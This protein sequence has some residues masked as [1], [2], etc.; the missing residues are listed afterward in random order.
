VTG[1]RLPR[2]KAAHRAFAAAVAL[3][4]LIG[5]P[6]WCGEAVLKG[7][8]VITKTERFT[9]LSP[10]LV[11]LEHNT[12]GK[13]VDEPSLV[14][15]DRDWGKMALA[16]AEKRTSLEITTDKLRLRYIPRSGRF[17]SLNLS[18]ELR[19]GG[20]LMT[21]RPGVV[22]R[23]NLG[24]AFAGIDGADGPVELPDG[25]LSR[26][27]WYLLND[28]RSPVLVDGWPRPRGPS[29]G[30]DLYF[31]GYGDDYEQG[32]K[33][34][35]NL[36]GKMP[37]PPRWTL[38]VWLLCDWPL[39]QGRLLSIVREFRRHGIRLDAL[40]LTHW[41]RN[42]WGSYEWN[43]DI[44]PDP[45]RFLEDAHKLGVKV[46]LNIH[47][48]GALLPIEPGYQAVTEIVGWDP[49]RRGMVFFDVSNEKQA[50]AL[51]DALLAPL[52]KQG[53]DF[54]WV[55]GSA[56][57]TVRR[58]GGQWWTNHL[59]FN[60]TRLR[61]D[62]RGL[63]LGRCAGLGSQ[64]FPAAFSGIPK[65]NW[66]ILRFLSYLTPTA[67]NAG[68][69]YMGNVIEESSNGKPDNE[70]FVRWLQFGMACPLMILRTYRG[71]IPWMQDPQTLAHAGTT[72]RLRR[73]FI[74]YLYTLASRA[75]RDG[76]PLCRPMYIH[77]PTMAAAYEFPHQYMLGRGMIIAPIA[78][79][80][81][82]DSLES[83]KRIW[84]PPGEWHDFIN[85][86]IIEGPTILNYA[87]QLDHMPVFAR[88]GSI[89][90]LL[91]RPGS[92]ATR[93][94]RL[95]L[96]ISAGE[97]GLFEIYNDDGESTAYL[98]EHSG[99][100]KC[101][102]SYFESDQA[103]TVIIGDMVGD[104][105]GKPAKRSYE[106][107]L[108]SFLPAKGVV[109]NGAGMPELPQEEVDGDGDRTASA[110]GPRPGWYYNVAS[111]RLVVNT[112][113]LP[114]SEPVEVV[115]VGEFG[116]RK[117][118]LAYLL[119]EVI[120]RLES[121]AILLVQS[122]GPAQLVEKIRRIEKTA[123]EAAARSCCVPLIE[124]DMELGVDHIR[125]EIVALVK[126]A[127]ETIKNDVVKMQFMQDLVGISMTGEIIPSPFRQVILRSELH[128]ESYG[129]GEI[130]GT[131]TVANREARPVTL[132]RPKDNVFFETQVGIDTIQLRELEFEAH[133]ELEWNGVPIQ[134][135]LEKSFDNT[136][137]KQ[138]YVAGPFGDGTYQRMA[139]INFPPEHRI[140][141]AASYVGKKG[142]AVVWKKFPWQAPVYTG[143][144]GPGRGRDFRFVDLASSLDRMPPS[145]GYAVARIFAP[146]DTPATLL[147]GSE[148]G[149]TIWM[150]GVQ[151]FR[152][153][154]MKYDRP[155]QAAVATQL[156]E[157]WNT[158]LV[159]AVDEGNLW[160]FYLRLVGKDR[161]HIP[162]VISGWG[163]GFEG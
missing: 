156:T 79:P 131:L 97:S 52:Q 118:R 33:D 32:L 122:K 81:P 62:K 161:Q 152:E 76:L 159:K 55:D 85:N 75:R 47:P 37:M 121:A 35:N 163:P 136:F 66:S 111:S 49:K 78:A 84:F 99:H 6:A 116:A 96:E 30:Q 117:R 132:L 45:V 2:R 61:H 21:W 142:A 98:G 86:K 101:V 123:E 51:T 18:I 63:I 57:V 146:R 145:A 59:V 77:Y 125:R 5:P 11:R 104:Y 100:A 109:V 144:E 110:R 72:L 7:N 4:A 120:P 157:G 68:V 133:A 129:W 147:I 80:A 127:N 114:T 17:T 87:S 70:L 148:G 155:D 48:G 15:V 95:T 34:F 67:G 107:R 53:V 106:V 29:P 130:K 73:A 41:S 40:V 64:R 93:H 149:L 89:T 141:L 137:I 14:A 102:V 108:S 138:F 74:P 50:R 44:F 83:A 154:Y 158:I 124:E 26:D 23:G 46:G 60:G 92:D 20:R 31:F 13:F 42:R 56:A 65:A 119:R 140:D 71:R 38:G 153:S 162:G 150:N 90:P 3:A 16:V 82:G 151:V 126:A 25:I 139:E 105:H 91:W 112:P 135:A 9:V 94:E 58:L 28:S 143:R 43:P 54:W 128:F 19:R 22:N 39:A 36:S 134:L 160:G 113:A 115:F 27:G 24:G 12:R 103:R 88:V 10:T 1:P 69:A 8:Q